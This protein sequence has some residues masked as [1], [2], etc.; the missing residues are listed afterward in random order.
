[1]YVT[2][3]EE[4]IWGIFLVAITVAM[5]GLGMVE[6]FLFNQRYNALPPVKRFNYFRELGH[7][8]SVSALMVLIHLAEVMM[9]ALF[10]IWQN[11][12][13]NLSVSFY[14]SLMEYTTL[15]SNVSLPTEW[16]LLGGMMAIAGFLAFAWSTSVFVAVA[17]NYQNRRIKMPMKPTTPS[18]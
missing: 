13:P 6:I 17:Q 5:H 3:I 18:A 9:W 2:S 15:G 14:F 10:F 8:L 11:I 12:L 1:M 4:I 7:L 16:K